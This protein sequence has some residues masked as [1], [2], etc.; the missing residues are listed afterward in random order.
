MYYMTTILLSHRMFTIPQNR[1][2]SNGK[3]RSSLG[4]QT[5]GKKKKIYIYIIKINYIYIMKINYIHIYIIYFY[6]ITINIYSELL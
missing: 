6:F 1:S 2:E 4:I 3:D 5:G